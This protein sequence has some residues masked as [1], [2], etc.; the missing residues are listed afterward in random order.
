MDELNNVKIY[1]NRPRQYVIDI[2]LNKTVEGRINGVKNVLTR[3]FWAYLLAYP[4]SACTD[5]KSTAPYVNK[6]CGYE[7]ENWST[8]YL[9][10]GIGTT[11]ESFSDYVLAG[12]LGSI[13]TSISLGTS[14]DR[15]RINLTGSAPANFS[16]IGFEQTLDTYPY[17]S[18]YLLGRKL[19]SGTA[20][21]AINYS[22]DLL[23]PWGYNFALMT[24]GLLRNI[25][26]DGAADIN[27]NLFTL[28]TGVAFIGGAARIVVSETTNVWTPS[29]T[30][31]A[32][33]IEFTTY[34]V[35]ASY[36]NIV[37]LITTGILV[38]P[39][40]ITAKS[41]GLVQ[42]LYATDGVTRECLIMLQPLPTP[43]TLEA[44]RTNMIQLRFIGI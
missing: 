6:L 42:K 23:S 21:Q 8:A 33:P 13:A 40:P 25:N 9:V 24:Y 12:G 44:N 38:P 35:L 34:H 39:A 10:Y 4:A 20:G 19:I 16:E 18:N 30:N 37:Y 41:V 3:Q 31:I 2:D 22:I 29:V 5:I 32:S 43:V 7:D 36:D 11:P 17:R 15:N 26:V 14:A 27:G 1:N 28:R